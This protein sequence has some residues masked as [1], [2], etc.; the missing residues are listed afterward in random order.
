MAGVPL[1][2]FAVAAIWAVWPSSF[3]VATPMAFWAIL[4]A[5]VTVATSAA[6]SAD[7]DVRSSPDAEIR[8]AT[9][10]PASWTAL[11]TT[12]ASPVEAWASSVVAAASAAWN[13]VASAPCAPGTD[14]SSQAMARLAS[15]PNRQAQNRGGRAFFGVRHVTRFSDPAN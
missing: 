2:L 5:A 8:L 14:L 9:V 10:L 3:A 12:S 7:L 1:A 13:S 11:E 4:C 6:V 15:W